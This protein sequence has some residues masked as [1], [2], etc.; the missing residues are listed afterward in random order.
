MQVVLSLL[1]TEVLEQCLLH[2][3]HLPFLSRC[4]A[5]NVLETWGSENAYQQR[6]SLRLVLY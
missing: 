1:F 6:I 3:W 2:S 5:W 4:Y